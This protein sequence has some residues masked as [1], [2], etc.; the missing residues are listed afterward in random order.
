MTLQHIALESDWQQAQERGSYPWSTRGQRITDV[1]FIHCSGSADQLTGVVARFYADVTEPLLVLTLDRDALARRG[2][3]VRLEP[4]VAGTPVEEAT[5]L[6]PHVYG[7]D[8][9]VECVSRVDAIAQAS[10]TPPDPMRGRTAAHPAQGSQ[11]P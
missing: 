7:G 1:G 9:P 4:P 5:E 11:Y 8:L 3:D 2:Y 6:F 10:L